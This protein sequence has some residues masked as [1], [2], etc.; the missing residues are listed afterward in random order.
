[1]CS[2]YCRSSLAFDLKFCIFVWTYCFIKDSWFVL[3]VD[4]YS[5]YWTGKST[6]LR[7]LYRFFDCDSGSVSFLYLISNNSSLAEMI[8]C[9]PLCLVSLINYLVCIWMLLGQSGWPRCARS[10]PREPTQMHWCCPSRYGML[11]VLNRHLLFSLVLCEAFDCCL[12][13]DLDAHWRKL[14]WCSMW[15]STAGII[16]Y[17][18]LL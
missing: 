9:V 8:P 12:S 6:I 18:E 13:V 5:V 17:N 16:I 4:V 7:L 15:Y 2:I 3:I 11:L 14:D 1:M 10:D